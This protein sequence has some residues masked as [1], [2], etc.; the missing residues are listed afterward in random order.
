MVGSLVGLEIVPGRAVRPGEASGAVDGRLLRAAAPWASS[1]I[2]RFFMSRD[3]LAGKFAGPQY[4][5]SPRPLGRSAT[6]ASGMG[7][8]GP[9]L[10]KAGGVPFAIVPMLY[11]A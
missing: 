9:R 10:R 6:S 8:A 11:C 5:F 4:D 1:L 2:A 3:S 7:R